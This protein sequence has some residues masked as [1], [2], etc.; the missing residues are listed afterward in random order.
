[1]GDGIGLDGLEAKERM[2]KDAPCL[3]GSRGAIRDNIVDEWR[4]FPSLTMKMSKVNR[5]DD[6]VQT[7]SRRLVRAFPTGCKQLGDVTSDHF[8]ETYAI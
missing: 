1:V 4:L 8:F 5:V 2:A 3:M 7:S 6:A